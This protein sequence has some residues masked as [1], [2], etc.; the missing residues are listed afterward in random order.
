MN[1]SNVNNKPN[2]VPGKRRMSLDAVREGRIKRPSRSLLYGPEKVGKSTFAA[3]APSPIFFGSDSGTEHLDIKRMPNPETWQDV[4]EGLS[5][6]ETRGKA[7]GYETLVVD[8]LGWFEP[9]AIADFAGGNP[10]VNLATWGGGHGAGYQAL[11]A[12][13]RI[14]L[15][16]LE[17]CWSA[18]LNIILIAHATVKKFDDP[19]GPA[20]E[21]YE[22][23][24][25]KRT[26]G[27]TKQWVD[28]IL[29]A[30]REAYGKIVDAKSTKAKAYGSAARMLYT[31]W[32][33]AYDAGNRASLPAEMPLHWATFA[34]AL[35]RGEKQRAL[36]LEQIETGLRELADPEAEKKVR[37]WLAQPNVDVGAVANAVASKL[38]EKREEQKPTT[39]E[40]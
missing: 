29:F 17:R 30:K 1:V 39:K 40:G 5:E 13:W 19:Q 34:E 38:G 14:F 6:I 20:F 36:L 4:L 2:G 37:E 32:N 23:A 24:L 21:R 26:A 15:K 25:D 27:P 8:P 11:E 31:E 3:G 35:E 9:L 10:A 18:G 22:L 33:P 7:T 16:S 12:Q 28:H